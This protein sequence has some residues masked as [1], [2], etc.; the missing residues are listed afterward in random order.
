MVILWQRLVCPVL[1]RL[2]A[3]NEFQ[4]KLDKNAGLIVG[5]EIY[6]LSLLVPAL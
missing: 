4:V 6:N 2:G 5:A 1:T 3:W